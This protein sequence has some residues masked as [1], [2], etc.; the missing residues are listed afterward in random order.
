MVV[1]LTTFTISGENAEEAK[2][3]YQNEVVP[4]V[5]KQNG[6]VDARL[7]EPADGSNEFISITSW[8]NKTDAEAYESSGKYK[9]LVGKIQGLIGTPELKTYNSQ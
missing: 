3:I 9:E 4:E 5:K 1:R 8:E 7:L 6:N 2:G